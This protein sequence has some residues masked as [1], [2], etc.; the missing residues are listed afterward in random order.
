MLKV[1]TQQVEAFRS[2]AVKNFE[3][4]MVQHVK[5]FFPTHYKL[6]GESPIRN[7]IR[8]GYHKATTYEFTTKRSVSIFISCMLAFGSS[9]DTDPQF[10]WAQ[11]I[12]TNKN[13]DP[14]MKTNNLRDKMIETFNRITGPKQLDLH[15]SLRH[16][17][18]NRN[19]LY[20]M[21]ITLPLADVQ[22]VLEEIYPKKYK[23]IC[24]ESKILINLGIR[25]AKQYQLLSE[26]SIVLYIV[27][28][29]MLGS[30]FDMD[31]QFKLAGDILNDITIQENK[32]SE[33]LWECGISFIG[34]IK[35]K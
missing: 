6:L 33:S 19:E 5:K 34:K 29:F 7:T 25:N 28:M 20:N 31:P 10:V 15:K 13:I 30:G 1:S 9:F 18:D 21:I 3:N 26:G 14:V 22:N 35:D 11:K 8:F 24:A 23:A 16:I 27:F 17:Y 12:L 4:E 32:K 2:S